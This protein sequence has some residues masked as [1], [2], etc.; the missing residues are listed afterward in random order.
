[1]ASD[2]QQR[3]YLF[4]LRNVEMRMREIQERTLQIQQILIKTKQNIEKYSSIQHTVI[5]SKKYLSADSL[6]S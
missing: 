6:K 1:M 3:D 2:V 5:C 4:E